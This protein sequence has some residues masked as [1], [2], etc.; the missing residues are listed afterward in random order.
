MEYNYP[1]LIFFFGV[2]SQSLTTPIL[3]DIMHT[4]RWP[5]EENMRQVLCAR[6]KSR[7]DFAPSFRTMAEAVYS[8]GNLLIVCEED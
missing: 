8:R 4:G 5:P 1:L 3:Y 2:I 7:L 6:C